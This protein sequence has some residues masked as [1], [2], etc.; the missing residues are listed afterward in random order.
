[1]VDENT[2]ERQGIRLKLTKFY[3]D[4]YMKRNWRI[5]HQI[6]RPR[7]TIFL[8]DLMDGGRESDDQK[9]ARS[10]VKLTVDGMRSITGL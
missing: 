7:I 8:G 2:Y 10:L 6:L 1:L 3:T 4:L 9:Y 5:M